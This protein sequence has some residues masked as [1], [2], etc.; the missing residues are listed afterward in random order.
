MR[1]HCNGKSC[2]YVGEECTCNLGYEETK[3]E[4]EERYQEDLAEGELIK[5]DLED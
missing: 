3:K 1:E 2:G 5:I 4:R